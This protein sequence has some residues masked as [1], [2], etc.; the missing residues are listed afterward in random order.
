MNTARWKK[1]KK[2]ETFIDIRP[3]HEYSK[4]HIPCAISLPFPIDLK[5]LKKDHGPFCHQLTVDEI[6]QYVTDYRKYL[7]TLMCKSSSLGLY[8]LNGGLRSHLLSKILVCRAATIKLQCVIDK[9]I[10]PYGNLR[11]IQ[12]L[13]GGFNTYLDDFYTRFETNIRFIKI[14][15]LTGSGKTRILRE[16]HNQ[17]GQVLD[18]E[19][20]AK[21]SG[22]AFG[23]IGKEEQPDQW[24]FDQE[25]LRTL[26]SFIQN[27][28][29][30][31]EEKGTGIGSL[32]IPSQLS[33]KIT[34]A[35]NIFLEV[36]KSQRIDNLVQTYGV[37][38]KKALK[39]GISQISPRFGSNKGEK[40]ISALQLGNLHECA[41]ILLDYYDQTFIYAQKNG[42]KI[43]FTN[44]AKTARIILHRFEKSSIDV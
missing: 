37:L 18:I 43:K 2:L 25:L 30:F 40:A 19:T 10:E 11:D 41:T 12:F 17:G 5:K 29:I 9:R 36:P 8:C 34:S 31:I 23:G 6:L 24:S 35:T 7:E 3:A 4:S 27:R 1:F 38:P 22:S 42:Q 44:L 28:P 14:C 26:E 39:M 33:H 13:E 15:G 32:H 16:I 20:I 21:H